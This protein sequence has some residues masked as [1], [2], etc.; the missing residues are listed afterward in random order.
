MGVIVF[1]LKSFVLDPPP[2]L[3]SI[4]YYFSTTILFIVYTAARSLVLK[5]KSQIFLMDPKLRPS[6]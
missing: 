6:I 1:V 2:T 4:W 3:L 5:N